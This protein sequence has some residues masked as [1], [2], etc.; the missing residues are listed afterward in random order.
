MNSNKVKRIIKILTRN[1]AAMA[2]AIFVLIALAK[3][4]LA[5]GINDDYITV[6]LVVLLIVYLTVRDYTADKWRRVHIDLTIDEIIQNAE[7][8]RIA[9]RDVLKT[10]DGVIYEISVMARRIHVL[11]WESGRDDEA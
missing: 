9:W 1:I 4:T 6:G 11:E 8:N 7:E 2:L 3:A 10:D 5:F